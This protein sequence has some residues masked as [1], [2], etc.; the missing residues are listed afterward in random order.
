MTIV[1][2]LGDV[3]SSSTPLISALER[4][5]LRPDSNLIKGELL[6]PPSES[7]HNPD[8]HRADV[9]IHASINVGLAIL[10]KNHLLD[11]YSIPEE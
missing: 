11:L 4:H 7:E 5:Q 1:H 9:V 10:T 3:I 6:S 8:V 2:L